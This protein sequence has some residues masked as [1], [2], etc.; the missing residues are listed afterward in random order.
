[1]PAMNYHEATGLRARG[2][3]SPNPRPGASDPATP[4]TQLQLVDA[5]RFLAGLARQ[6]ERARSQHVE[7]SVQ[8]AYRLADALLIAG[9]MPAPLNRGGG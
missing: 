5:A 2:D 8:G 1:M 7:M 4:L 9:G 6:A 3:L